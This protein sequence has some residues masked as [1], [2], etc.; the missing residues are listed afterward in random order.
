MKAKQIQPVNESLNPSV[1]NVSLCYIAL[2]EVKT[3]LIEISASEPDSEE[4]KGYNEYKRFKDAGNRCE[5]R[6]MKKGEK[7]IFDGTDEYVFKHSRWGGHV[8]VDCLIETIKHFIDV[9]RIVLDAKKGTKHLFAYIYYSLIKGLLGTGYEYFP[10]DDFIKLLKR[11][12]I[13]GCQRSAL[14]ANKPTSGVEPEQWS[15]GNDKYLSAG[16]AFGKEFCD[17]YRSLYKSRHQTG[18]ESNIAD[19]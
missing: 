7:K 12:G 19:E 1:Q 8:D 2:S 11:H 3:Q 16:K 13:A 5:L 18:Q 15:G 9:G 10:V 14:Y 6:N 4:R 17:F